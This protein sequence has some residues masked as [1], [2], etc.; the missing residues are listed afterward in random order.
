MI[1]KTRGIPQNIEEFIVGSISI[2]IPINN[3][4]LII[5]DF[6]VLINE[7]LSIVKAIITPYHIDNLQIYNIPIIHSA[8][9]L[10]YL[11]NDDIVVLNTN[12]IINT[13]Y[14]KHSNHNFLFLTERCNSNCLMCSQPPK[15]KDDIE[16][17]FDVNSK[18]IKL[19]PQKKCESLGITGGEP[20]LLGKYFFLLIEQLK[21]DLPNTFIQCLTNGRTFA[22]S[23]TVER[24]YKINHQ[25]LLLAIPLYS[26]IAEIHDYVVQ[27][28]GAFYQTVNG[29]Y[30]LARYNQRIEIRVVLH[31]ITLP[32][33]QNLAEFIYKNMPF[34]E[35]V[36]LMGLE[37]EGYTPFNIDKLWIDPK[38][39]QEQLKETVLFL[40]DFGMNVSIYNIP[41]CLL[42]EELWTFSRKSISDWKNIYLEECSQCTKVEECG[43]LFK[44][45]IK[46]NSDFLQPFS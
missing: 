45:S 15:D 38:D 18:L 23:S 28:K 19:I 34:V 9:V 1:L 24:L 16:Y 22:W 13:L 3:C 20:T 14:R 10:N 40:N 46:K 42:P 2:N 41:L 30:N 36:A 31:K 11:T 29:I 32:R 25:E 5:T 7:D 43:G 27:A 33:L 21:E 8:K 37:I 44:S 4:I 26:D 39:Y 17:F 6:N 12:G 35:H